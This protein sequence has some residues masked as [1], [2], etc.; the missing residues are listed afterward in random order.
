MEHNFYILF[1]I[2]GVLVVVV[3]IITEVLKK[4]TEK[5]IS[6]NAL[7]LIISLTLTNLSF[8][9]WISFEHIAFQWYYIFVM[10]IM[11]FFVAYAAM[12]GFDKFKQT[13]AQI[14]YGK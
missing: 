14:D 4:F 2:V 6:T 1:I 9:S 10:L 3:N 11:G 7:V 13:L 12:F 8:L 5:Y